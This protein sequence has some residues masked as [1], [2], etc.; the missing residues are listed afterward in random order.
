MSVCVCVL[1]GEGRGG[2]EGYQQGCIQ[3]KQCIIIGFVD[4]TIE[5]GLEVLIR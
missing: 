1:G 4:K 2:G 3:G 5:Q